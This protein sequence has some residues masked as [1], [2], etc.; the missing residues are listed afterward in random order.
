MA[1][2]VESLQD[3]I[4][5]NGGNGANDSVVNGCFYVVVEP[6]E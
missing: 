5:L 2:G 6:V 3:L 4:T 1:N